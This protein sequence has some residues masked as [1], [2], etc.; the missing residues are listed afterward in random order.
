MK[1]EKVVYPLGCVWIMTVWSGA[2][3][4]GSAQTRAVAAVM[5][6]RYEGQGRQTFFWSRSR[7][8]VTPGLP[9]FLLYP[10]FLPFSKIFCLL[11]S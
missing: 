11:R 3:E 1:A 10:V 6:P 5:A 7:S 8:E 4:P 9:F 2:L